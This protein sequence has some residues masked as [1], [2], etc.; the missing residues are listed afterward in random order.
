MID[1]ILFVKGSKTRLNINKIYFLIDVTLCE[2][3]LKQKI[4]NSQLTFR[5]KCHSKQKIK[6]FFFF[7][8]NN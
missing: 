3:H 5:I 8:E 4:I 2:I 6:T 1:S 7:F